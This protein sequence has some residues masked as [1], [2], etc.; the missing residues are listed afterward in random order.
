MSFEKQNHD[1]DDVQVEQALRHFRESMHAWSELEFS[2]ERAI[3]RTRWSAMSRGMLRVM[4]NPVMGW[5]LACVLAVSAISVPVA[6]HHERELAAQAAARVEQAKADADAAAVRQ[7]ALAITD[8]ELLSHVD[9]DI[10][11]AAPDAME[12]LARLM[13]DSND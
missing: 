3:Q 7:A 5:G 10:A 2:R 9:S 8:E 6:V 13:G 1:K 11:Q 12:P 4:V